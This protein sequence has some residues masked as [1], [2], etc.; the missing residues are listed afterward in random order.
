MS[1]TSIRLTAQATISTPLLSLSFSIRACTSSTV[2]LF[3]EV[4]YPTLLLTDLWQSLLWIAR[5][6]RQI[7]FA[8]I[9]KSTW[10]NY[11]LI[12]LLNTDSSFA[13]FFHTHHPTNAWLTW[14]MLLSIHRDRPSLVCQS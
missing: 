7:S 6:T 12:C 5:R 11:Q 4:L 1:L 10:P 9:P 14:Y 8:T 3:V 13:A 2:G